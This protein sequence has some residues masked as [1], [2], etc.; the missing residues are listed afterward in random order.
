MISPLTVLEISSS[1]ENISQC[2]YMI[3]CDGG[4][5]STIKA[6]WEISGNQLCE[7]DK[8]KWSDFNWEGVYNSKIRWGYLKDNFVQIN[9]RTG[10]RFS[11]YKTNGISVQRI[12]EINLV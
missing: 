7:I 5:S 11:V 1:V 9:I 8:S 2:K 10:T 6:M 3:L 4:M 12:Q